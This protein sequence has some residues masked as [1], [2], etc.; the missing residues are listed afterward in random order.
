[1]SFTDPLGLLDNLGRGVDPGALGVHM[2]DSGY[3]DR[4]GLKLPRVQ[5]LA[6][7]RLGGARIEYRPGMPSVA[8]CMLSKVDF[9]GSNLGELT[10]ESPYTL[11]DLKMDKIQ[12][13]HQCFR[14]GLVRRATFRRADLRDSH[15]K[16]RLIRSESLHH[17]KLF[18]LIA[19]TS[20]VF[21]S[22]SSTEIFCPR[23]SKVLRKA[24]SSH[25]PS[26]TSSQQKIL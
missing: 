2:L 14:P 3:L 13:R 9:T 4:R 24:G 26:S 15:C 8:G 6:T 1:M 12:G 19:T 10:W 20:T 17:S 25:A 18:A 22:A 5:T 16:P 7:A 23:F 21:T 11:E